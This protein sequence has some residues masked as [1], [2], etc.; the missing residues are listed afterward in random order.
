[1]RNVCWRMDVDQAI[2]H[3]F[4]AGFLRQDSTKGNVVGLILVGKSDTALPE[5]DPVF[6]E[7]LAVFEAAVAR[8][9]AKIQG[10]AR[11]LFGQMHETSTAS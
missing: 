7:R 8:E 6:V 3:S 11:K 4:V 5:V 10:C 2:A 9:K 1:M